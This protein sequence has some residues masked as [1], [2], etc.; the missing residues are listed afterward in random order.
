[1]EP[2]NNDSQMDQLKSR[3]DQ[4]FRPLSNE[5]RLKLLFL[6]SEGPISYTDILAM[7][8][9]E[10][11]SFY[12]HIKKMDGLFT[13]TPDKKYVLN[14]TGMRVIE[15]IQGKTETSETPSP[16]IFILKLLPT[17]SRIN[18]APTW[19][20]LQ[21]SILLY[22]LVAGLYN[23]TQLVQVGLLV[24]FSTGSTSM[25]VILSIF[26]WVLL[27]DAW[28]LILIVIYFRLRKDP[29]QPPPKTLISLFIRNFIFISPLFLPGMVIGLAL[30][31]IEGNDFV[32][33]EIFQGIL[34]V[35]SNAFFIFFNVLALIDS[36]DIEFRDALIL[37]FVSIYPIAVF[38]ALML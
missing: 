5:V 11:G 27:I 12:W 3:V 28:Q 2:S 36:L 20:I 15:L 8:G 17:V 35:V 32:S 34:V 9:L 23:A 29:R 37:S 4:I 21:Q 26:Q 10:S 33:S 13:Q 24:D 25:E 1:M 38:S 7:T 6:M 30:L 16:P 18:T 22:F 19:F 14:E 31:L